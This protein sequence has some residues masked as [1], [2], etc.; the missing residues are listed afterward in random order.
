[1][2]ED[3][4]SFL[5]EE[6]NEF[7]SYKRALGK[8]FVTE[9]RA[10][11]LLDCYFVEKEI[12]NITE[13]TSELIEKFLTSRPR[14]RPRSYNHLLGVAKRFFE[15]LD[16]YGLGHNF[17]A[18][19]HPKRATSYRIPFLFNRM[20]AQQLL[21][22][23]SLLPD[24]NNARQRGEVYS[25]IF[26]LLYGLGLRVGE[27][28]RLKREDIDFNRQLLVI[29]QTKFAKNRLVP[30]GPKMS[31]SLYSYLQRHEERHGTW[32]PDNPVFSFDKQRPIHPCTISQTFH[33]LVPH[34]NLTIPP[35]VSSPRLHD[36]RHSFA[37]GA[38][39]RWYRTGINPTQRLFHLSTFMG[40]VDPS[41]TAIYLTITEDILKEAN[42]RFEQFIPL[43]IKEN[44]DHV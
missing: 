23:A 15:W 11:K 43:S 39:L 24:Q 22:A 17:F 21:S 9:E 8:K 42:K 44:Q 28:S 2:K 3:F 34:L 37:V 5:A 25:M 18:H 27:A 4:K 20:Q 14:Y 32:R 6:M 13:L 16:R 10:L 35:G 30:F 38:L 12:S 1:M 29:R 36:L 40:H 7:I 33:H 31:Q 26:A 41:S 19:L